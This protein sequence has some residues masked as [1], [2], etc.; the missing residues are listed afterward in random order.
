HRCGCAAKCCCTEQPGRVEKA[1]HGLSRSFHTPRVARN[2]RR[3]RIQ[4]IGQHAGPYHESP[5]MK[6]KQLNTKSAPFCGRPLRHFS[7]GT[8]ALL[9]LL[10]L[11]TFV[12]A[13]RAEEYLSP[14]DVAVAAS[15]KSIFVA[16]ATGARVIE[17][18]LGS[19]KVLRT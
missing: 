14:S 7:H 5:T 3:A 4:S 9:P 16:C 15:G 11:L 18:D 10:C 6:M 8:F 2:V 1:R 12:L 17:Y 19:A 13:A